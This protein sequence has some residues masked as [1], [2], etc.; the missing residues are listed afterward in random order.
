MTRAVELNPSFSLAYF[1]RGLVLALAARPDEAHANFDKAIRLSPLDPQMWA[2]LYGRGLA[3]FAAKQYEQAIDWVEQSLQRRR[4]WIAGW[5]T[6]AS[7]LAHL[8][9]MQEAREAM[10]EL[11]RLQP[12]FTMATV[13]LTLAAAEPDF[14]ERYIDGLRKAGLED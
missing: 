6:L 5:R 14:L 11:Q 13:R 9:R 10:D 7:S 12:G 1:W 3:C 2:F 8:D 4:D